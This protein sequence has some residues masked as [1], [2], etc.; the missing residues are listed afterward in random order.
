MPSSNDPRLLRKPYHPAETMARM[1][2]VPD[3]NEASASEVD[4]WIANLC[5]QNEE[6]T[7]GEEDF[8]NGLRR[9]TKA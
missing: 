2:A 1:R 9:R 8:L 6:M 7:A 5:A 3:D 4:T